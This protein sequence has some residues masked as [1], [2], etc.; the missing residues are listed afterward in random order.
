M[1][2]LASPLPAATVLRLSAATVVDPGP[3]DTPGTN[4]SDGLHLSPIKE[5]AMA[6]LWRN[7]NTLELYLVYCLVQVRYLC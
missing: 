5:P 3:C 1:I 7:V 6:H 2:M 4:G